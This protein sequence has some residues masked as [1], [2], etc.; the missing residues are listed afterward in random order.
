MTLEISLAVVMLVSA[1]LAAAHAFATRPRRVMPE[2]NG[3]PSSSLT[4]D[5]DACTTSCPRTSVMPVTDNA[6]GRMP[7]I[8]SRRFN[9]AT[10]PPGW[11]CTEFASIPLSSR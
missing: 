9:S 10:R 11:I 7:E 1:G 2:R 5:T 6:R 3:R 4:T 8:G